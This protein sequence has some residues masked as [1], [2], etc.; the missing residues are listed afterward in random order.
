[1]IESS[2]SWLAFVQRRF[3]RRGRDVPHRPGVV[4]P[5]PQG[6]ESGPERGE[7]LPEHSGRVALEAVD[8]LGHGSRGVALREKVDVIGHHFE[9]ADLHAKLAA[10]LGQESTQPIGDGID[11]DGP[12]I[13]RAPHDVVLERVGCAGVLTITSVHAAI[14]QTTTA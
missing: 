5:A 2:R 10:L 4:V 7:L 1:M 12:T 11:Q 13:L 6:R 14:I 8:D 9:G 3:D